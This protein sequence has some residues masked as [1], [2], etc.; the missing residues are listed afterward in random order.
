[1]NVF[2]YGCVGVGVASWGGLQRERDFPVE[3]VGLLREGKHWR[4]IWP[5]TSILSGRLTPKPSEKNVR[6]F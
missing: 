6:G 3:Y 1:M 5:Q 2:I 4:Y